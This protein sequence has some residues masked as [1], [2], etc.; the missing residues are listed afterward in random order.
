MNTGIARRV[1]QTQ[2]LAL[3]GCGHSPHKDQ[4]QAVIAAATAFVRAPRAPAAATD[5]TALR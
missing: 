5:H 2:L 1:P 4:P 3:P